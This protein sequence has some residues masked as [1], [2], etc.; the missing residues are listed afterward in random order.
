MLLVVTVS[1]SNDTGVRMKIHIDYVW[2]LQR[3]KI[4]KATMRLT[5]FVQLISK[6][7]I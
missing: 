3:H 1:P 2:T 6:T 4:S 7:I 5:D